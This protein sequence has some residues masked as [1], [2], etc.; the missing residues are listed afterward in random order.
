MSQTKI[1][2]GMINATS[3]GDAKVLQGDGSWVTP[4]AGALTFISNTDISSAATYDFT[5]FTAASYEHYIFYLQNVIPV[6][7]D[8]HMWVRT[9]TD[10]G[11]SYDAGASDYNWG[12]MSG[13][14]MEDLDSADS[15]FAATG[16]ETSIQSTLGS[17][18]T[19]SGASGIIYL[20]GPHTTSYTQ[21]QSVLTFVAA[22]NQMVTCNMGGVRQSAG[23]VDGF[24][25][26]FE[27]G[28]IE[29]GTITVYGL[30]NA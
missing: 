26:L 12:G 25:I 11:S 16:N 20:Y 29:S 15:V 10:G 24:R 7:D 5:A 28:S 22:S 27:S 1:G 21:L 8:V 9:S 14:H 3:I 30:A 17:T 18:S 19:E 13:R 23:D 6:T 2:V 4:S